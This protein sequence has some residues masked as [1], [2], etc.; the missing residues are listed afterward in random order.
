MHGALAFL[1]C[2]ELSPSIWRT[3][4]SAAESTSG[5]LS[6]GNLRTSAESGAGSLATSPRVRPTSY[7]TDF[8]II[9]GRTYR[10]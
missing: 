10:S 6:G 3:F 8:L 1:S 4:A 7:F 2:N 9:M 5:G